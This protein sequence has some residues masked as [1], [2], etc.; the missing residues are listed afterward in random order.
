MIQQTSIN[1]FI[2][3]QIYLSDAQNEVYNYLKRCDESTD[4]EICEGLGYSDPNKIRPRRFELVELGLV[5][6]GAKRKCAITGKTV[7]TWKVSK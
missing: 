6:E 7:L 5:S 1:S 2:E 3:C 4:R